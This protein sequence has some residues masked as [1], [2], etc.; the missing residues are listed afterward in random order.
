[1]DTYQKIKNDILNNGINFRILSMRFSD[2]SG[3]SP[4]PPGNEPKTFDDVLKNEQYLAEFNKRVNTAIDEAEK[5]WKN[6]NGNALTEA[7]KLKNMTD[8]EREQYFKDESEKELNRRLADITARELKAE[9]KDILSE[10]GLPRELID[11]VSLSDEE[12]CKKSIDTIENVFKKAVAHSVEEKIKQ[13]SGTPKSGKE[14]SVNGVEEA[15]HRM[16]PNLR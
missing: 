1:M 6:K 15:F 14:Q 7:Q 8:L 5:T 13:S 2:G 4:E 3:T 10:K 11:L 16:N 9:A 12:N